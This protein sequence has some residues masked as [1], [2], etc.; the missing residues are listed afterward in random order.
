M[1][2][3]F[4]FYL[5]WICSSVIMFA[6]FYFWHGY[7]LNDFKRINFPLTWFVSFAAVTYLIFGFGIYFLYESESLKKIRNFIMRG[8]VCG[9]IAGFTLF[10]ISTILNISLTKHLSVEHLMID[11]VWQMTEQTLGAMMVVVFKIFLND[12]IHEFD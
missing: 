7:F 9:L 1:I 10:M 3:S 8:L 11:C 5:S 12:P 4:R 2:Y 6:L